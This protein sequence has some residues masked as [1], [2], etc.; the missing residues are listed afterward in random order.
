MNQ[1]KKKAQKRNYCFK[2]SQTANKVLIV[3]LLASYV[4]IVLAADPPSLPVNNIDN[5]DIDTMTITAQKREDTVIDT[6]ISLE[7]FTEK[8]LE[9]R[10]LDRTEDVLNQAVNV[11]MGTISGGL[12]DTFAQIRGVGS[13]IIDIDPSVGLFIDDTS[14]TNSQAYSFGLLDMQ[15]VEIL[16]GPQGTLYGRNTLGGAVNLIT[17]KP[18]FGKTL[19]EGGIETGSHGKTQAEG[20]INLPLGETWAMRL[21]GTGVTSR[22]KTPNTAGDRTNSLSGGQGR[23]SLAGFINDNL[24]TLTVYEHSQQNARDTGYIYETDFLKGQNS[25]DITRPGVERAIND[26]LRQHF[27]W[28]SDAGGKLISITSL[29]K[30]EF[31][32][33]GASFPNGYFTPLNSQ[34]STL[35]NM[36]APAFAQAIPGV[37]PTTARFD[38]ND[39]EARV[40]N[41]YNSKYKLTSQE[42]RYESDPD[43]AFRWLA[44]VYGEYTDAQRDYGATSSYAPSSLSVSGM[45]IP[46]LQGG[47]TTT[48]SFGHTRTASVSAFGDASLDVTEQLEVFAGLRVSHDRKRFAYNFRTLGSDKAFWQGV[49]AGYLPEYND[50]LSTTYL[51]PRAGI[52]YQ[53][54]TET[55]GYA[56]VSRGFKTGGFNAAYVQQGQAL[57][58]KNESLMSYEIGLK[59]SLIKNHLDMNTALFYIDRSNQQV[60]AV[61]PNNNSF[62]IAN[63]P[64]SHSYGGELTLHAIANKHWSGYAGIGYTNAT[65]R[66]FPDASDAVYGIVDASGKQQQYIS[67]YTG[68]IGIAY[69]WDIGIDNLQGRGDLGY[70]Y[71]SSYYFDAANNQK[72]PGYGLL[73]TRLSVGNQHYEMYVW[74]ENLTNQRYR[75][76]ESNL[77]YGNMVT[78]GNL[79][80][81]GVGVK[82]K[83]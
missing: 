56:S 17:N 53:F 80:T 57:K 82:A 62:P 31:S 83:F 1:Q 70:Q 75:V 19:F 60:Q 12:Y 71:R 18:Q 2:W 27:T 52:R 67:K 14:V 39:F 51:T 55:M 34:M 36:Y 38:L 65:Y 76:S 28:Y 64:K 35:A 46:M 72:Q 20:I 40:N 81:F 45:E 9:N 54:T 4:H 16:R 43:E 61:D 79:R 42:I 22:G 73:N 25:V 44:G 59:S 13:N 68:N 24:E 78:L 50:S 48:V 33:K 47:A 11:N 74:G 26:N 15:R 77:G 21:A 23:I 37:D 41:P 30:N 8:T 10:K 32:T 66:E 5:Q 63:A 58:Y 3:S 49:N 29:S 7:V 6:P 69:R